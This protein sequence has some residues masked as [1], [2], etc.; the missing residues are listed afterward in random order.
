MHRQ[1]TFVNFRLF[2]HEV[3]SD[4]Q[5][6]NLRQ[7]CLENLKVLGE[8]KVVKIQNELFRFTNFLNGIG[9]TPSPLNGQMPLKNSKIESR[10]PPNYKE[11]LQ[12]WGKFF[13]VSIFIVC[14]YIQKFHKII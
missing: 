13:I 6:N 3:E 7:F 8:K 11:N 12:L 2:L 10:W 4:K 5:N 14:K 1:I 9:S